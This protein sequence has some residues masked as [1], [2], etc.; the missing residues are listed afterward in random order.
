MG[1]GIFGVDFGS[2]AFVLLNN[3]IENNKGRYFR[4]HERTFQYIDPDHIAQ[5]YLDSKEDDSLLFDFQTYD[6]QNDIKY[7]DN[8]LKLSFIT[9]QDNF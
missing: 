7:K 3:K 5:L 1:R 8:G 4:L 2:T 9:T 6:T